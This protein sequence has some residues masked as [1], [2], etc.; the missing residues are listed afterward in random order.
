MMHASSDGQ[1][2]RLSLGCRGVL[3]WRDVARDD[4][5]HQRPLWVLSCYG[6]TREG[7]NDLTGDISPEEVGGAVAGGAGGPRGVCGGCHGE[8]QPAHPVSRNGYRLGA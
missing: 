5:V 6:H 4:L 3:P 7:P 8:D 1:C 2:P